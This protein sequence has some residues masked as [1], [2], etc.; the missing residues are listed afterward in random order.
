MLE[1]R[2][3]SPMFMKVSNRVNLDGFGSCFD[4]GLTPNKNLMAGIN[5]EHLSKEILQRWKVALTVVR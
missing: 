4:E 3:E 1:Y 5:L 2:M